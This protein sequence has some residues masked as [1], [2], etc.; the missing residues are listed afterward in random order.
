MLSEFFSCE[1]TLLIVNCCHQQESHVARLSTDL[2]IE[3]VMSLQNGLQLAAESLKSVPSYGHREVI[4]VIASLNTCDPGDIKQTFKECKVGWGAN[5][6]TIQ[7]LNPQS[8]TR[9]VSCICF[10]WLLEGL[11]CCQLRRLLC[12]AM[13]YFRV[14]LLAVTA[15]FFPSVQTLVSSAFWKVKPSKNHLDAEM[16]AKTDSLH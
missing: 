1:E 13:A 2:D 8:P 16:Q 10:P 5:I 11:S 14:S 3:G 15:P 6:C 9:S 12:H 4:A 7:D